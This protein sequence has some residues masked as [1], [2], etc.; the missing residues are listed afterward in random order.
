MTIAM[1]GSWTVS[2]LSKNASWAQRF[3]ING[4]TN[5]VDGEYYDTSP[6]VFVTGNQ[7]GI[8]LQHNPS[9]PVSWIQSRTRMVRFRIS[10]GQFLFDIE[11]NDTG[12]DEDFDDLI[13]TC[14]MTQAQSEYVVYGTVKSYSGVCSFNPCFPSSYHVIDKPYQL[15]ELLKDKK[16]RKILEKIYPE[17]IKEFEKV[18]PFPQ[19]DPPPFRPMMIP[20][21]LSDRPGYMVQPPATTATENIR[22]T[23]TLKKAVKKG[24]ADTDAGGVEKAVYTLASEHAASSSLLTHDDLMILGKI[25]DAFRVKPCEVE[26]VTQTILRFLEYDR[27]AAEKLGDPYTGEGNRFALGVSAT[28]EFGTYLYRFSQTYDQLA[29][30]AGDM[31]TGEDAAMEMRPDVIIQ[32]L[33]TLPSGVMYET[34]PYYNIPNIKCINLCIPSE[35]LVVPLT[36]CQGGRAIQALGNLSIITTG[37]TLHTDGTVSNSN[38]TGPIVDHAAWYETLD[39]HACF[40]DTNPRVKYYT[41]RSR[42]HSSDGWTGWTYVT[43]EYKHSKQQGDGSWKNERVGPDDISLKV[44]GPTQPPVLVSAYLNIEDQNLNQEWQNWKRDRK[45]Q[46]NTKLYQADSGLVEYKIQ[47]YDAAGEKVTAAV[48]TIR[49]F[50]DNTWTK[51]DVDYVKMGAEDP[52]ECALFVLPTPGQPLTVRYRVTDP[53]GFMA[54]Y[55]LT[56]YRGSNTLVPTKNPITNLPVNVSYQSAFPYRF[57]GTLDETVDTTGYVEISLI[58]SGTDNSWLA[59]GVDFCAFSFELTA[60]D[61]KTNGTSKPS[62][63]MLWRELVGITYEWPETP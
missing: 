11:G 17:R 18:K 8:T 63:H 50:V 26:P 30:E 4:S 16:V 59:N 22:A 15:K 41:L 58:P 2:V 45:L 32:L 36:S 52:G 53:E 3:V 6:P 48:D 19:P 56:V 51:G 12:G 5:G 34:A 31:T 47:G 54:N 25:K 38:E 49:L 44:N 20:S 62:T 13:L 57:R 27:T 28:D 43:E 33:E 35:E 10:G 7:W 24:S 42:T 21:G 46:I 9:G 14:S 39:L 37:T 29:E 60:L 40:L 55:A 61:R 23:T 1:Q